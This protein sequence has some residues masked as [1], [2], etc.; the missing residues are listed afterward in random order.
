MRT[1]RP[2]RLNGRG[3]RLTVP[4]LFPGLFSSPARFDHGA[5]ALTR[6]NSMASAS[7]SVPLRRWLVGVSPRFASGAPGSIH[8]SRRRRGHTVP[9][10]L[11]G[12]PDAGTRPDQ[13][14]LQLCRGPYAPRRRRSSR[15]GP[16]GACCTRCINQRR[17]T[18]RAILRR[19][20]AAAT[21]LIDAPRAPIGG[22]GQPAPPVDDTAATRT[23]GIWVA[24]GL[25]SRV[26][27]GEP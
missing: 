7:L 17:T 14:R 16:A 8:R 21:P 13:R 23:V 11:P 24:R 20:V 25:R 19:T 26:G 6:P 15:A 12:S 3:G 1:T 4:P 5:D 2:L 22:E 27:G 9:G 10:S 18:V